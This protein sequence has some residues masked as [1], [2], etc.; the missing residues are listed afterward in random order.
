MV[1]YYTDLYRSHSAMTEMKLESYFDTVALQWMCPLRGGHS[2]CYI[3]HAKWD[4]LSVQFYKEYTTLLAP[5]LQAMYEEVLEAGVLHP[6]LRE[7][8]VVTIVKPNKPPQNCDSYQQ[9]SMINVENK[10]LARCIGPQDPN[11]STL[12]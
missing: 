2:A 4:G 12:I 7:A 5:R 10:I 6:S 11:P 9:L 1:D 8:L 3:E